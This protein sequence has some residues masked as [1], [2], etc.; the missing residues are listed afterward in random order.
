MLIQPVAADAIASAAK[1]A[2]PL[3]TGGILVGHH[4]DDML[5]ITHAITVPATSASGSRY[6]RD[7][8]SANAALSDYLL[9]REPSDPAG[10]VGEWHSHP[11]CSGVRLRR[12][13]VDTRDC[14]RHEHRRCTSRG[15]P[16]R[17]RPSYGCHRISNQ[18]GARGRTEDPDYGDSPPPR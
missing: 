1:S 7:D 11:A 15:L 6:T 17:R 18:N 10:Y 4:E 12:Y 3:E 9:D 13:P 16:N 5:V 2:V 14:P 8:L